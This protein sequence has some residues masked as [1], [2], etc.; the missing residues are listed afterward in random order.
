M[1]VEKYL[2]QRDQVVDSSEKLRSKDTSTKSEYEDSDNNNSANSTNNDSV[3]LQRQPRKKAQVDKIK[4]ARK[5][6]SQKNNQKALAIQ[7]QLAL[8][9]SNQEAQIDILLDSLSSFVLTSYSNRALLSSLVQFLTIL[10]IDTE[11]KRLRTAKN[12]S[13]MLARLVY[14]VRVLRAKKLLP[15]VGRESQIEEDRDKFLEMRRKYLANGSYSPI[16][17]IISLLAY[18]KH[19]ALNEG[20]ASNTYQSLDKTIFYLNSQS[21]VVKRFR[22]IAQSIL[23]KV[24]E[25]FQQLC[26]VNT[27]TD[28]FTI[29][30]TQVVDDVTFTKRGKSFVSNPA[31]GLSNRLTQMLTKAQSKKSSMQLQTRDGQQRDKKVQQYLLQIDRFLELLLCC[32]YVM[33]RQLGRGLEITTIRHRNGLLQN[34]NIFV[35]DSAVITVVRY[36]KSQSQQNKPKIMPRFLPP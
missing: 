14:C 4:N 16:S 27:I 36:Y 35:V 5:L 28:R 8:D 25:R 12:Y 2:S 26:Q 34:C 32:V 29:T 30:L 20:N 22:K 31:N 17:K 24:V 23:A 18:G 9:S 21:I 3:V 1:R 13:Y 33:S 11:T 10:G 15:A 6:F 19:A 7:L